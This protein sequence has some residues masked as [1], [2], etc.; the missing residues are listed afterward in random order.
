M[1]VKGISMASTREFVKSKYGSD[2]FKKW[3][4]SLSPEARAIFEKPVLASE[5]YSPKQAFIEPT[6]AVCRMFYNGDIR[7]AWD[8]GRFSAEYSLKGIYK[9]FLRITTPEYLMER[10][11][12]VFTSYY[13][14][15][16]MIV[17]SAEPGKVVLRITQFEGI[18]DTIEHRMAGWLERAVELCGKKSSKVTIQKS[19]AK[20][21]EPAEFLVEWN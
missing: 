18:T 8:L 15:S 11:T 20:T 4:E 2:D 13:N 9:I 19:M 10:A 5:W 12:K 21:K 17:A 14:P 3:L 1:Q 7:G 16:E 6:E